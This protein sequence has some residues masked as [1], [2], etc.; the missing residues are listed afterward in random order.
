MTEPTSLSKKNYIVSQWIYL[1]Y[2][3]VNL[4]TLY[5][6]P[7]VHSDEVWLGKLSAAYLQN[8]SIYV[9]EPFFIL[10][11]RQAHTI[12]SLFHVTQSIFIAVFGENIFSVRLLSLLAGTMVLII[13]HRT[14][15]RR[16]QNHLITTLVV[17]CLGLSSQ[18][19]YAARFGRQEILMFLTLSAA[20][21]FYGHARLSYT[22]KLFTAGALIGL[23]IGFHP[24]AFILA[25]MFFA[26][27]LTDL[28]SHKGVWKAALLYIG[29]LA[30]F[31]ALFIISSLI[32]N[33]DFFADY[34]AYGAT[35]SVDADTAS[36]LI[37]FRD[38]YIKLYQQI[39]GTY[40]LPDIRHLLLAPLILLPPVLAVVLRDKKELK[41][42]YT[43]PLTWYLM[44]LAYNTALFIIGRFNPTS[45]VFMLIPLI[46][47]TADLAE[48][49]IRHGHERLLILILIGLTAFTA[50]STYQE[51]R[52]FDN[53]DYKTYI[54]TIDEHLESDS[55]VL[56]NLSGGFAYNDHTLYD[57]RDLAYLEDI[58][59]TNYMKVF[60][61]NT[62]VYYEEYDYINRNPKWQI[63]YGDDKDYY[64]QLQDIIKTHG[65]LVHE[66]TDAYYG[67][68]IIRYIGDY[69][70]KI[71]IYRIDF[72]ND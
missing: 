24:N 57:I 64:G 13:L 32:G 15:H 17:L 51:Y 37:N 16:L 41:P 44:L 34:Y 36:R 50:W 69:P 71:S 7:L 5:K 56:G 48:G 26:L 72:E 60:G 23:S 25:A 47:L 49:M 53:H 29:T 66:F 9:T 42:D 68:R 61:I 14:L 22:M 30:T 6:Y 21:Y 27:I 8:G 43:S 28:L 20:L 39:S 2:F 3:F 46:M 38:F 19:M 52:R 40:F 59:L 54:E 70:W 45:I 55:I 11:P 33:P 35:L 65:T 63:L 12:K 58:S 31:A 1:A 67:T 62:I 4:L 10:F 18:F